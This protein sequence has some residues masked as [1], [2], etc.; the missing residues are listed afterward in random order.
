MKRALLGLWYRTLRHAG[1]YGT[2]GGGLLL[3]AVLLASW[4]PHLQRQGQV[5]RIA[6]AAKST[7]APAPGTASVLRRMPVGE[8]VSEFVAEFPPLSQN[9]SDLDEVFQSARRRN[10]QLLQGEYQLKQEAN[11]PL[12]IYTATFPVRTDYRSIKMFTADVLRALPNAAMDELRMNRSA[13]GSP[14][15]EAVIKFSFVYRRP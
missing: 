12:V 8:Q 6:V 1:P 10:V 5:L 15:L 11:A 7:A 3:A 13:S 14:V 9:P 2:V 4:I